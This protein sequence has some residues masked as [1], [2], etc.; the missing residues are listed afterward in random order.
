MWNG[1]NRLWTQ[2]RKWHNN[3][4]DMRRHAAYCIHKYIIKLWANSNKFYCLTY[5]NVDMKKVYA[6]A[7]KKWF[8]I[9]CRATTRA[10][11]KQDEVEHRK[12]GTTFGWN[13][14]ARTETGMHAKNDNGWKRPPHA[15]AMF[16]SFG[17]FGRTKKN[18]TYIFITL[19]SLVARPGW[20][21][22]R[23]RSTSV[24]ALRYAFLGWQISLPINRRIYELRRY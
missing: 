2:I 24:C 13:S 21:F 6:C 3:I 20:R 15:L 23:F 10:K 1:W 9:R 12:I 5:S 17:R 11:N 18:I 19:Q 8:S 16:C 14:H 4:R 22:F 7:R